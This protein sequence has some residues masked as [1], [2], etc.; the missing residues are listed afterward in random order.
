[1]HTEAVFQPLI[2]ARGPTAEAAEPTLAQLCRSVAARSPP[3]LMYAVV[4]C[5]F[6]KGVYIGD[7]IG[8]YSRGCQ[9]EILG[10]KSMA[11]VA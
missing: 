10:V 9:G 1:M 2:T 11:H 4:G 8:E 6:L 7:C 3:S 5:K